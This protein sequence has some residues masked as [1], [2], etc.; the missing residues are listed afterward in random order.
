MSVVRF[1]LWAPFQKN[2]YLIRIILFFSAIGLIGCGTSEKNENQNSQNLV[3]GNIV[4]VYGQS[5]AVGLADFINDEDSFSL[6][7][8]MYVKCSADGEINKNN[9]C[10]FLTQIK[11]PTDIYSDGKWSSWISFA[12]KWEEFGRKLI[13]INAAVSGTTLDELLMSR[14]TNYNGT[15]KRFENIPWAIKKIIDNKDIKTEE[16]VSL[17]WIQGESNSAKHIYEGKKT[18][19]VAEEFQKYFED[20]KKLRKDLISESGID[21]LDFYIV[22]IGNSEGE[23]SLVLSPEIMNDLGYWQI[24]FACEEEGFYPL[25]ILP[26]EFSISN[27]KLHDGIHYS[28]DAYDQLGKEVA[29]NLDLYLS[30]TDVSNF[31]CNENELYPP[32]IVSQKPF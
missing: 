10:G 3:K 27:G 13:L 16:K 6:M 22:R 8:L 14:P 31:I 28:R 32:Q 2:M 21:N 1:H 24:K 18:K 30:G 25:S 15:T 20:L 12:Q 17:I 19:F 11:N 9:D 29:V 5:N 7:S 26:K 4:I 23:P